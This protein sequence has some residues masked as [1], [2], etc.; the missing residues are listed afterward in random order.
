MKTPVLV[1]ILALFFHAATAQAQAEKA[2]EPETYLKV[3]AKG[4]LKVYLHP[5]TGEFGSACLYA[6]G[7]GI[8]LTMPE[9]K[10]IFARAK[11]LDGQIVVVTGRFMVYEHE[12]GSIRPPTY[13]ISVDTLKATPKAKVNRA[14][15]V[16]DG[17]NPSLTL[18]AL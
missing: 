12:G 10:E 18:P 5:K 16:C 7:I 11:K 1:A 6:N 15:S 9:N 2:K 3:E 8:R 17:G 4:K 14:G 13:S